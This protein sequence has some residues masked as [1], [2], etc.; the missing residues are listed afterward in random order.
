M[1]ADQAKASI[2][3]HAPDEVQAAVI[4]AENP[5]MALRELDK[6]W[7]SDDAFGGVKQHTYN[8]D[9]NLYNFLQNNLDPDVDK[10]VLNMLDE[11][12]EEGG[13]TLSG[14]F[15]MEMRNRP[16]IG[17]GTKTGMQYGKA[18]QSVKKWDKQIE[19]QLKSTGNTPALKQFRADKIHY[20][21]FRAYEKATGKAVTRGDIDANWNEQDLWNA[22]G[23][24]TQRDRQLAPGQDRAKAVKKEGKALKKAV[25]AQEQQ[26][27]NAA[28]GAEKQASLAKAKEKARLEN[29]RKRVNQRERASLNRIDRETEGLLAEDST[30]WSRAAATGGLGAPFSGFSLLGAFPT[31]VVAS[32]ALAS[33]RV[34]R[35]MAGQGPTQDALREALEQG[36][37]AVVTQIL[38][39]IGAMEATEQ[40]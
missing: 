10:A 14:K 34:Q 31:G 26:A 12:Y 32:S 39:R 20:A 30:F 4:N 2:P 22:G 3:N 19:R 9:D 17:S 40:E 6:Y 18:R 28:E 24:K 25:M 38:T 1:R 5:S 35:F 15:L 7:K 8:L 33:P 23:N 11:A 21:D 27:R 16:A 37:T 29:K 13:S 36:N